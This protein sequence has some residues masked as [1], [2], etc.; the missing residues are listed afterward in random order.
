MSESRLPD[1][2]TIAE[3]EATGRA[4]RFSWLKWYLTGPEGPAIR[5]RASNA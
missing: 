2:L 4:M 3:R 1:S 5:P